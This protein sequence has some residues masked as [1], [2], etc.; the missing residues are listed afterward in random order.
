LLVVVSRDLKSTAR[1]INNLAEWIVEDI[2]DMPEDV[3]KTT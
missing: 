2:P 1:A 3:K